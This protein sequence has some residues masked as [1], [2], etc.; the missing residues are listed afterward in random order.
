MNDLYFK[1][2]IAIKIILL[3]SDY[4]IGFFVLIVNI[5]M[6]KFVKKV[7]ISS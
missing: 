3:A 7:K 5:E 4:V 2:K 1:Y 6:L